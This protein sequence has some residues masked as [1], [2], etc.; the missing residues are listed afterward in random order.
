MESKESLFYGL[1]LLLG[2][3][4]GMIGYWQLAV[5][6]GVGFLVHSYIIRDIKSK[7]TGGRNGK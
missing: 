6:L 1:G 7:R 3:V 2:G 5:I 4:A